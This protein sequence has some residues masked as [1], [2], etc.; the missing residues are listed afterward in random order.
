MNALSQHASD[1][2]TELLEGFGLAAA[3]PLSNW[4]NGEFVAGEGKRS[5]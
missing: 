1:H 2:L 3:T 4:I 5:P